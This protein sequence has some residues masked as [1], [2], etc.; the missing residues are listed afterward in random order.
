MGFKKKSSLD[1]NWD[2]SY[3]LWKHT[4]PSSDTEFIQF[5]Q[6]SVKLERKLLLSRKLQPPSTMKV[7]LVNGASLMDAYNYWKW[8]WSMKILR[9]IVLF[10]W[11]LIHYALPVRAL[12]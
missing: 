3:Y 2:P 10:H 1:L 5:F 6:Y 8:L 12:L 9:N 7:W 4:N 11:L